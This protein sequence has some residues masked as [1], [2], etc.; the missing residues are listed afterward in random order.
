[1]LMT[2]KRN[3]CLASVHKPVLGGRVGTVNLSPAAF[4][5]RFGNPHVIADVN[6]LFNSKRDAYDDNKV[7]VIWTFDTPRGPF[8]VRDYW[9]N[10]PDELSIAA[11]GNR[12]RLWAVRYLKSMGIPVNQ[13]GVE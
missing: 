13:P 1:M 6:I 2:M 7:T 11:A 4:L 12:Q 3:V 9:W 8:E 5:S 10:G